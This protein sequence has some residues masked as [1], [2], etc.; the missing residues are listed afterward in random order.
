MDISIFLARLIGPLYVVAGLG[1]L[2]NPAYYRGMLKS[3]PVGGLTYYLSGAI[4]LLAGVAI[5]QFHNLWVAD[6][7]IIFTLLG[8]LAVAKGCL[9][10]LFPQAGP[11]LAAWS[12]RGSTILVAAVFALLLGNWLCYAGYAL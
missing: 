5:L 10:L 6:W 11:R 3:L 7:R 9:L 8:W 4:A 2:L 12:A 1:L